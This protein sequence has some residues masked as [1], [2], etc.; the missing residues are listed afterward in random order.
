[1][2]IGWRITIFKETF[3][4]RIN[5]CR[6][7]CSQNVFK[8][9]SEVETAQ[10]SAAALVLSCAALL[11]GQHH[12]TAL[13][14]ALV[15]PALADFARGLYRE[16]ASSA[17]APEQGTQ[18]LGALLSQGSAR[19]QPLL[20]TTVARLEQ[21]QSVEYLCFASACWLRY[22]MGFDGKGD[23]LVVEDAL[24]D[25]LMQNRLERWDHIDELTAGYLAIDGLF[26]APLAA[27]PAFAERLAY[28]LCVIL[29]NGMGTALQILSIECRD[30]SARDFS[31]FASDK[32][33]P[34]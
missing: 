10:Q 25:Q 26:P 12:S 4:K 1:M 13:Q 31:T 8:Q 30:Y 6:Q 14:S 29:A 2:I 9:E 5:G 33:T 17:A 24:A 3:C 32:R 11:S 34:A 22:S 7:S 18:P 23:T 15:Y 20:I 27:Q 28:W 16:L 21:Q 19:L